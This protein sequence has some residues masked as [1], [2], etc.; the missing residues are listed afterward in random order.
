MAS[1]F[2]FSSTLSLI[3]CSAPPVSPGGGPSSAGWKITFTVPGRRSFI[4]ASA[5][6]VPNRIAMW[7]S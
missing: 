1:T 4:R 5:V 7:L 2:G 6:A 3:I